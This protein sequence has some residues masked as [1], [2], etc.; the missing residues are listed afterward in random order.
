MY[1]IGALSGHKQKHKAFSNKCFTDGSFD[2]QVYSTKWNRKNLSIQYSISD[3]RTE[4]S[5]LKLL[6][7]TFSINRIE[8]NIKLNNNMI[9]SV[10]YFGKNSSVIWSRTIVI[11]TTVNFYTS[12]AIALMQC[13]MPVLFHFLFCQR[14]GSHT[15][16]QV[17]VCIAALSDLPMCMDACAR[18]F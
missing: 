1:R 12:P 4:L 5:N 10:Q 13:C 18:Y 16:W 8:Q 15:L 6:K 3:V 11:S 7:R 2:S 9:R 14:R 17:L